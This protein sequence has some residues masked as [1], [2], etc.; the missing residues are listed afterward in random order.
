MAGIT[1]VHY[2][3]WLFGWDGGLTNFLPGWPGTSVLLI[4]TS[5]EAGITDMSY[6]TRPLISLYILSNNLSD[7]YIA[8]NSILFCLV[9]FVCLFVC[10]LF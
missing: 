4:Y 8:K 5:Q 10:L 3:A 9:V 6:C 7:E 1:G 2:H